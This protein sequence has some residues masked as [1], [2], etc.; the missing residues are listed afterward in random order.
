L[1]AIKNIV[2]NPAAFNAALPEIP[3]H[4]YF[5]SVPI[6]RD[7]DVALA[8][9]LAEMELEDFR[10]LNPSANKPVIFAAGTPYILLPWDNVGIFER[11]LAIHNGQTAGWT[12][13]TA[14]AVIKSADAARKFG[15]T[16]EHFR[17]INGIPP[18][19]LIKAGSTLLV[20]RSAA[21]QTE[22]SEQEADNAQLSLQ[23]EVVL[24]K[25]V[26]R[27]RH[28]ESVSAV[29]NRLKVSAAQLAGWNQVSPGATFKAKQ[30]VVLFVPKSNRAQGRQAGKVIHVAAKSKAR[31]MAGPANKK[32]RH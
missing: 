5:K 19:M 10:S 7:M 9:K 16:E 13:W 27:L 29:A 24:V 15:L 2:S 20:P 21:Q 18:R 26:V 31:P 3:N 22:V 23:P 32:K 14:P 6:N 4:P 1:Q 12:V 30:S 11:N 25:R 8:A 17:Q 28:A